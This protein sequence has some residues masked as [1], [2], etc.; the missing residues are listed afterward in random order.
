M[1]ASVR[2]RR[3]PSV[4][5]AP[6]RPRA[7]ARQAEAADGGLAFLI[8]IVIAFA[9]LIYL[10]SSNLGSTAGTSRRR[11]TSPVVQFRDPRARS[12]RYLFTGEKRRGRLGRNTRAVSLHTPAAHNFGNFS[13]Q[14]ANCGRASRKHFSR[15]R[16]LGVGKFI[17]LRDFSLRNRSAETRAYS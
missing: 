15:A 8:T 10:I 13:A 1:R 7:N 9:T 5:E 4:R 17:F 6:G 14:H 3:R 11:E 16:S 12:T 2:P